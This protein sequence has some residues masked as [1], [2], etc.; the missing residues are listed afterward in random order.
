M[1]TTQAPAKANA[2]LTPE[3]KEE[4]KKQ[5]KAKKDAEKLAKEQAKKD[6]QAKKEEDERKKKEEEKNALKA[7]FEQVQSGERIFGYYPLVQ[8]QL[9]T[10][11][12][13]QS[14]AGADFVDVADISAILTDKT[15][16]IRAR[17]HNTRPST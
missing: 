13:H 16:A 7:T 10:I 11:K 2:D 14:I 17:V 15:I 9:T 6:A 1:S 5:K 12:A 4:L 3:E 8:S